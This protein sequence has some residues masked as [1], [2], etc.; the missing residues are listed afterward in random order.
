MDTKLNWLDKSLQLAKNYSFF[1]IIKAGM[2][3]VFFS[4]IFYLAQNPQIIYYKLQEK[5]ESIHQDRHLK[6]TEVSIK[7][8]YLLKDLLVSSNADRAWLIEYHNGTKSLTGL[9]FL[10]G[11][12]TSEEVKEGVRPVSNHFN[13]FVLS[14]F[15]FILNASKRGYWYGNIEDIKEQDTKS[16]HLLK[17]TGVKDIALFYLKSGK[18]DIGIVG[19]SYTKSE[20]PENIL[21]ILY[22]NGISASMILLNS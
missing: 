16:Y 4:Y 13:D 12:M 15:L 14:D 22:S 20:M 17:A 21:S 18:Q 9:P 1:M 10:Y 19:L 2:V 7:M 8:K 6:R 3:I 5:I 11:S